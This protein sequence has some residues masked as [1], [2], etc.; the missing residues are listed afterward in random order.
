MN[1]VLIHLGRDFHN[2]ILRQIG[3]RQALVGN[4]DRNFLLLQ[5]KLDVDK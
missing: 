5:I 1:P 3:H 4:V 2:G